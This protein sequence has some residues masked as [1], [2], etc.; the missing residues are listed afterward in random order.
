M[1]DI[2][3]TQDGDLQISENGDISLTES[4]IQAIRIRLLWFFQEWRFAP[5]YGVPYYEEILVKNP[6]LAR[7]RRIIKNEILSVEGVNSV[8]H[9]TV[10]YDKPSRVARISYAAMID[11]ED[12]REGVEINV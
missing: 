9:V 6:N 2:L 11:G 12:R 4:I 7:I 8:K 3:L 1:L 5:R 10:D